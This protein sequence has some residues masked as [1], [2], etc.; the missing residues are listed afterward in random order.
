MNVLDGV[1]FKV[2]NG[3]VVDTEPHPAPEISVQYCREL[4]L[5]S[6]YDFSLEREALFWVEAAVRGPCPQQ[7][8]DLGM[9]SAPPAWFLLVSPKHSL[10]PAPAEVRGPEAGLQ[11][12][13]EEEEEVEEEE[14]GEKRDEDDAS[15]ASEEEMGSSSPQPGSPTGRRRY[16][17][18][19]L[20]NIRSELVGARR[21]LSESRLASRPRALLHRFR[22]HRTLSLSASLAPAPGP[23]P[24]PPSEP[25]LPPRPS[26]AGAMPPLR[27]HK[28]TVASLS[29]Y[30]CLPPLSGTPQPLN[31]YRLHPDSATDLLSALTKE[32]QDLIWPVVA[33]GYPLGRAI[34]ALQKTGR[35]SLS[36]FLGY[37][38]ACERLLRQGYDEALVDEAMEMFQFSEHQA[39]EFLRL[40][41]QFS[42]MGFQ[43]D[44]IKEVLLVHG[45]Q[46]EQALEELVACAQ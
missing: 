5:G 43:Q 34:V 3:L 23:A 14:I 25:V 19:V 35:Q 32:E 13:A 17:L 1:P 27:S 38:G 42:D 33:L 7:C 8:K 39:G 12:P 2:P 24:Q 40:W 10:M 15:S 36:Q 44:R 21:R 46:R 6:M 22:G 30:T 11:E 20:Q 45:N 28:P 9:A 4:L 29:P 26:T 16:S 37:L 18:D 41:Q 31:S